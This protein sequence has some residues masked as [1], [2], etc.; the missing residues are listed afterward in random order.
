M[1]KQFFTMLL[2][3]PLLTT[4]AKADN[5]PTF[6]DWHDMQV[7]EINRFPVHTVFF[8][9]E[10]EELAFE[11]KKAQSDNYLSTCRWKESGASTGWNMPTSAPLISSPTTMTIRSGA[12]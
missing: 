12:P 8:A 6:T 2:A 7:N 4:T 10:N 11:G 9:Y 5:L 1:K 3:L